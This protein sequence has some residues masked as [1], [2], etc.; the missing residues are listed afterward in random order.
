VIGA[1]GALGVEAQVNSATTGVQR[2][3]DVAAN[4]DGTSIIVWEDEGNGDK[5]EVSA[6][7][8]AATGSAIGQYINL[9]A[10]SDADPALPKVTTLPNGRFLVASVLDRRPGFCGSPDRRANPKD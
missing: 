6:Q 10:G 9:A 4:P 7:L 1:D 8:Y 2:V 3:P 5:A